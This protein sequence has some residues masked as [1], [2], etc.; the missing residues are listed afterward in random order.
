MILKYKLDAVHSVSKRVVKFNLTNDEVIELTNE[1]IEAGYENENIKIE[2]TDTLYEDGD[3]I[4][5]TKELYNSLP[6]KQTPDMN[7]KDRYK[8]DARG[9]INWLYDDVISF[10]IKV[11]LEAKRMDNNHGVMI[12]HWDN[13]MKQSTNSYSLEYLG[14]KIKKPEFSFIPIAEAD[15]SLLNEDDLVKKYLMLQNDASEED[16]TEVL[17]I[18]HKAMDENGI[19]F[20]RP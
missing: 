16:A 12:A 14:F 20:Y 4:E 13:S 3:I 17:E 19:V 10:P 7:A 8:N 5:I 15:D 1:L 6:K 11:T 9:I 2:I 18:I